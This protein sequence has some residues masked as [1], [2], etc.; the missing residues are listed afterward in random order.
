MSGSGQ[1][2]HQ[3]EFHARKHGGAKRRLWRKIH[4]GIDEQTLKIRAIEITGSNIGDAPMLPKLLSQIPA[5]VEIGSALQTGPM[6]HAGVMTQSP[7]EAAHAVIP[8]R[9]NARP[10]KPPIS[11]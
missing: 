9:K 8:P 7:T 1:H 3:G 2:R 11:I 5:D 4:I 6:S 10:W